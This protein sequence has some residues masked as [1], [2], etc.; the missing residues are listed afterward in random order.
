MAPQTFNLD[1]VDAAN[2]FCFSELLDD[3]GQLMLFAGVAAS[4]ALCS[5]LMSYWPHRNAVHHADKA[6]MQ[7]H[8]A[9]KRRLH[10]DFLKKQ[11]VRKEH[12]RE[13]ANSMVLV[14]VCLLMVAMGLGFAMLQIRL[15]H[16]CPPAGRGNLLDC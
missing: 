9:N 4:L 15:A 3:L 10:E 13:K 6:D 7:E 8:E 5:I 11:A 2:A 14:R 12:G 1:F 16:Q